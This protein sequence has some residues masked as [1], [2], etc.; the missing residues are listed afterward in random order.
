MKKDDGRHSVVTARVPTGDFGL[1]DSLSVYDF[2]Q[3]GESEI[4]LDGLALSRQ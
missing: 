1:Q 4:R 2:M 3:A